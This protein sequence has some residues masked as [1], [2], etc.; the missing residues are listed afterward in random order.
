MRAVVLTEYGPP[1]TLQLQTV[2]DPTPGANEIAVRMAG[3]SVNPIDWKQRSGAVRQYFPLKLPAVLGRDVSGTVA[4]VGPG[5]GAFA[6]GD[7]VLGWVPGGGY[8]DVVVAA[9]GRWA[10][11]PATLDLADAGALPLVALTGAQLAEQAVDAR[12]GETILVTG[13]TGGVGRVT[14]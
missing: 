6:I 12:P 5:G 14:V 7:R 10:R 9:V 2:P 1:S 11:V 3:A 4:A 8:A 13:A